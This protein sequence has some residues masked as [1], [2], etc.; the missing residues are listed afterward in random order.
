M[1]GVPARRAFTTDEYHRMGE[2]GILTEDDRVELIEGEIFSMT[3]IGT[4]HASTVDRLNALFSARLGS[5]AI[6]RV[7][8]PVVLNRHSEPQPDLMLLKPR[9]DF[10]AKRHPRPADVLLAVEVMES[11]AGYDRGVKFPLYAR[12]GVVEVW[13]VDLGAGVVTVGR[14]PALRGYREVLALAPGARLAPAAFPRVSFKVAELL[15]R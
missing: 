10:Y 12:T 14:R 4:P 6:V 11:S 5:R 2:T 13:L 15:G 9:D 3:P 8:G 1:D 7:Q